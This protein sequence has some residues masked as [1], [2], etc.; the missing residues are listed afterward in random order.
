MRKLRT[1]CISKKREDRPWHFLMPGRQVTTDEAEACT[2]EHEWYGS[3][4][5]VTFNAH[6]C[7]HSNNTILKWRH[8]KE[9]R[10]AEIRAY[11]QK[12][13]GV[14][15][16]ENGGLQNTSSSNTVGTERLQK[17]QG[18]QGKTG[19]TRFERHGHYLGRSQKTGNRQSRMSS[20]GGPTHPS[21]CGLNRGLK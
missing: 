3:C 15:K 19:W 5:F 17:S 21:R 18:G 4:T 12:K 9:D 6:S 13:T 11:H 2:V 7:K 8:Q 20:T 10:V 14:T 16:A 1:K